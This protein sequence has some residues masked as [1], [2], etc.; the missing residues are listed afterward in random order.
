MPLRMEEIIAILNRFDLRLTLNGKIPWK[1]DV[2]N[3]VARIMTSPLSPLLP[4]RLITSST[5][6]IL[7]ET[8]R[9]DSS[10][11][12]RAVIFRLFSPALTISFNY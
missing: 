10:R 9:N 4:Y 3:L 11:K 2:T 1:F 6:S 8:A 5:E 7:T 12:D